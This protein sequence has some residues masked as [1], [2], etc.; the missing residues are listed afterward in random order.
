MKL[1]GDN[2]EIVARSALRLALKG[3]MDLALPLFRRVFSVDRNW[4]ELLRRLPKAGLIPDD[5]ATRALLKRVINEA[6]RR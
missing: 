5:D 1:G 3:Q 4:V 2:L 6:A